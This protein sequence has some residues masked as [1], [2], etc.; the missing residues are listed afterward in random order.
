MCEYCSKCS[1]DSKKVSG[2][3]NDNLFVHISDIPY[4]LKHGFSLIDKVLLFVHTNI[5]KIDMFGCLNIKKL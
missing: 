4:Q 1:V 2:Y 3:I 5:M